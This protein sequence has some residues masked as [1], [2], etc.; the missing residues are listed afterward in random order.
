MLR[1]DVPI[2][3]HHTMTQPQNTLP[4][5]HP[6]WPVL[7]AA[8]DAVIVAMAAA[9]LHHNGHH[10]PALCDAPHR[11]GSTGSWPT[12]AELRPS[13]CHACVDGRGA[14]A[15]RQAAA[16]PGVGRERGSAR[17]RTGGRHLA[18]RPS[19]TGA[20]EAQLRESHSHRSCV[21]SLV[22]TTRD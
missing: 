16:H 15:G 17:K 20:R 10:C 13:V 6:T 12:L 1:C 2:T 18:R 5:P 9:C 21:Q 19:A 8:S 3:N 14:R 22:Q 4:P 7:A 11:Y